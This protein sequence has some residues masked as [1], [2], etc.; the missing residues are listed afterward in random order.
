MITGLLL[1]ESFPYSKMQKNLQN[2]T[3]KGV[4]YQNYYNLL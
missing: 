3:Y 1:T 2:I 4:K